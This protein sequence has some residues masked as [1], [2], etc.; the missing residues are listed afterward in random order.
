MLSGVVEK[1]SFSVFSL[2]RKNMVGIFNCFQLRDGFEQY[3]HSDSE[4]GLLLITYILYSY[5]LYLTINTVC[6]AC[7]VMV[8]W[9]V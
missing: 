2:A 1:R 7:A 4:Y 3:L 6:N 5:S 8:G 9:S